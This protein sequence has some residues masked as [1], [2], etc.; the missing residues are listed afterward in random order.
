M[1][2]S[3]TLDEPNVV[4]VA[5]V[6]LA[7]YA[8]SVAHLLQS[9]D[10]FDADVEQSHRRPV[11]IEQHP[12]HC[13]AHD[14]EVN[15][16]GRVRTNRRSHVED[17]R[18]TA[19]GR[20]QCR[21]RRAADARRHLQVE[22]RH[23]HQRAG[24]AGRHR[25]I[26]LA[27]LDGVHGAPHG[28]FPSSLSQRDARLVV[29]LHRDVGVKRTRGRRQVWARRQ[30]RRNQRLV[31]EKQKLSVGVTRQR[32]LGAWNDDRWTVVPSHRVERNANFLRHGSALAGEV[33]VLRDRWVSG[34]T[35]PVRQVETMGARACPR[36]VAQSGRSRKR[37]LS[38]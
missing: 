30:Q 36:S 27:F 9:L 22:P 38:N 3:S 1:P 37:G 31:A 34:A 23:R 26:C 5:K 13:A 15:Q 20:P 33:S 2:M 8:T 21:D 35:I 25:D 24:I 10:L 32:D 29:H 18:F 7:Q 19:Q 12:C 16:V 4:D 6:H 14:G 11:E 17:D 28:R